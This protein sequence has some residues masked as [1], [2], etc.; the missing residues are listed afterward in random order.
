MGVL[1]YITFIVSDDEYYLIRN[2]QYAVRC[3][4]EPN[5]KK[6]DKMENKTGAAS[7]LGTSTR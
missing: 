3:G 1:I 5:G 4:M 7:W 2:C 6:G